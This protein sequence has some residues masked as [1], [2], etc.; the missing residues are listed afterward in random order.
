MPSLKSRFALLALLGV[1][2][3]C[4]Y[5]VRNEAIG[6]DLDEYRYDRL[7]PDRL[8]DTL[9]VVTASGGGTRAAALTMA[10]LK[11]MD[12]VELKAGGTLAEEVD[13]LSSV[14]GGSVAAAYFALRGRKGF[15]EFDREFLQHN[16]MSALLG[17]G[18][19]QLPA[20]ATPSR[21]R[22]D[23]LIDY[24]DE[25]LFKQRTYKQLIDNRRRPYLIL[26][27]AD[28]VEGSPFPFTQ[29]TMD[30]LCSDLTRM[31]LS[32]AVAASAAFPV[33]FSPVS[34][35]NYR[36]C[37]TRRKPGWLE[38]A[39]DTPWYD[40]PPRVMWQRTA[41][42]YA[43]GQKKFVHLLDGGL[44]DNLGVSE[45]FRLLTSE[46]VAP[47]LRQ[48]IA[49][50]KIR[51]IV[52]VLVNARSA[53][54][55]ELDGKRDT[56]GIV[57]MLSASISSTLDRATFNMSERLRVLLTEFFVGESRNDIHDRRTRANFAA[58]ARET[59][60]IPIDFHA[61]DDPACRTRFHSIGTNWALPSDTL[62][63]LELMGEA[64]LANDPD[65][66]R[67]LKAVGAADPGQPF[68][69]VN[70]ACAEARPK[71]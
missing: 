33:A 63:S 40:D 55:S 15:G 11:A 21:E 37:T 26:N 2:G 48:Q 54:P 29:S 25:R 60:L 51:K 65:F 50:G 7:G 10:V 57:D 69:D 62:R 58:I 49:D 70:A 56:P 28:M 71:T 36:P 4:T 22:I 13:I 67:M 14:S 19:A 53:K 34:L 5:P 31:K 17:S 43:T 20:L 27:A 38:Q 1:L 24:F 45:P 6:T 41:A 35:T 30:L 44:A 16:G 18:L 8:G 64:L 59:Y 61:I 52:F 47:L 66:R 23:I 68:V 39:G 9:V 42:P 46:D 32:T 3:A 12:K